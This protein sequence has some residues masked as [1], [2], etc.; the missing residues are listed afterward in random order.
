MTPC[1][2]HRGSLTE[3]KALM[4]NCNGNSKEAFSQEANSSNDQAACAARVKDEAT[5]ESE[6]NFKD[7]PSADLKAEFN[8]RNILED[9]E[10]EDPTFQRK[11]K[12]AE[13]WAMSACGVIAAGSLYLINTENSQS[14]W[15]FNVTLIVIMLSVVVCVG[16][17]FYIKDLMYEEKMRASKLF[18]AKKKEAASKTSIHEQDIIKN[19]NK[20]L[21]NAD[22]SKA[23]YDRTLVEIEKLKSD[24]QKNELE[25]AKLK[26]EI[27]KLKEEIGNKDSDSNI[28]NACKPN[29]KN[30]K[31]E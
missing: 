9:P 15:Q 22:K 23:W 7:R 27:L 4:S 29:D 17:G 19:N 25:I 11:Y 10:F 12:Y 31:E 20:S 30:N 13:R 8:L 28:K 24:K 14:S 2:S 1:K 16:C 3:G 6:N 21:S 18:L 5:A 26:L